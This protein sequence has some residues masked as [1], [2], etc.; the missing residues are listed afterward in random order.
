MNIYIQGASEHNLKGID[1]HIGD[2]L[3][4][5]TG[6]SGSGKTSL[7]FDTLYHEARRRLLSVLSNSRVSDGP[8]LLSP[9]KVTSITG[10]GPAVLVGQNVLNRNP[11]STLATASGLHPFLRLLFTNY[12]IR[13]CPQCAA[14]VNV[15]TEDEILERVL[16]LAGKGRLQVQVPLV[17]GIQG[18]HRTL[19]QLLTGEFDNEALIVDGHI[20]QSQSLDPLQAHDIEVLVG[21]LD[22]ETQTANIRDAVKRAASMGAPAIR[23]RGPGI[24]VTLSRTAVCPECGTLFNKLEAK[25]FHMVCLHCGG[26]GC[27]FCLN[28]G[29]HP[30]AAHVQWNGLN[31]PELLAKPVNE[32]R[33]LFIKTK[34][35]ASAQRL[36]R[37]I[38]RRLDTLHQVGLDYLTLDRPSP[39]LSRGESQRVRLAVV[40]SCRLE[41]MLHILDEPTIGQHPADIARFL[42]IF[43]ELA[44]PVVYVEHDRAAAMVADKAIELGPGAGKDG[45]RVTFSGTPSELW[46]AD[47]PTGRYFSLREHVMKPETR[48]HPDEFISLRG[49]YQH[50]LKNIDIDIPVGRLTVVTGV[51]GSGKST[52]VEDVLIPSM[53]AKKPVGCK[54]IAGPFRKI[55]YIDQSPIGH[56]PRSN[57][58]TYTKLSD[59]IRDLYAQATG[60]SSSHFSFNRPEG[61]CPACSGMGSIEVKMQLIYPLWIQCT[62]C[63]GKRFSEDILTSRVS[64]G[65]RR[66]SIAEFYQLSIEEAAA[67]FVEETRIPQSEVKT[68]RSILR[69]LN[70]VGLGYLPLGQPSTTLSGGEAQR[71]KLSKY[72]GRNHIADHLLVLDEPSTGLHPQDLNGLLIV[73][74]RLIQ[75]GATVV[76]IEHNT[77][78]IRAADWIIDLGP[79]GGPEG[80]QLLFSGAAPGLLQVTNSKTAWA[81]KN[82]PMNISKKEVKTSAHSYSDHIT[83]RNGRANNLKGVNVDIPKGKL[84]V[85]TGLSGSGKSSLVNNVLE[86]EAQRRYLESLSMYE[87]QGTREGPEAPVDAIS[88]LGVTLAVRDTQAHQWTALSQFTRRASVGKTSELSNCLSVL[89]AQAGERSC[90]ECGNPMERREEWVCQHCGSK[91]NIAQPRHFLTENYSSACTRCTGTGVLFSPKPEKLIVA[92]DKPLCRGAMYSPGYWPQTYLCQDQPVIPALGDRYGFDPDET[93]WN[94]IP[95]KAKKAFLFGDD[96]PITVTYRSKASGELKTWTRVWEG[97]YGGWV[98][99]WDVHGTYTDQTVC[100]EC[101]GSGLRREYM[102]VTLAD[103]NMHEL[104]E[105]PLKRLGNVLNDLALPSQAD[106]ATRANLD[107]A[108][109]RLSFINKVGLGYLHLDRASGTLSAGE[110]QRIKLAGLLG[111]RLASLTVLLDEPSR[112]M[113]PNELDALRKVLEDLRDSD[114]TVIVVEHDLQIIKAADHII[115]LGP[116]AGTMGGKIV[117]TGTP[118]DIADTDT[119]T[120]KWLRGEGKIDPGGGRTLGN[121]TEWLAITG[122]KEN[123][124]R[125]LDVKIPLHALVGVCGVSG[126]GKSTLII[127]TL[128]RALVHKTHTTSFAREPLEPG[129]YDSI[130]GMPERT[131]IVDQARENIHNPATFLGLTA[132]L[133]KLFAATPDAKALGLNEKR[134]GVPCSSCSGTGLK[135]MDMAFLPDV[136]VECETCTGTGCIPEAKEVHFKGISLPEVNGLTLEEAYNL[137]SEEQ[138]LARP[139]KVTLEVGLGYLVWQQ[140]AHTLSGGEAQR[141]KIVKELCRRT[142][143]STLYI[144]DEPTV[145]QHMEDVVKLVQVLHRLVKA[146]HSV[147]VIEHQPHV[148]ASCDWII[149]LGP[150][151]GPEGGNLIA[152]GHPTEVAHMNTPTARYIR[153]ALMVL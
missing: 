91:A 46:A 64:F 33:K 98:R 136:F 134:L 6:I 8:N 17:H 37:E 48:K 149:E 63:E 107:T 95:E 75:N 137:F 138:V 69:A 51:S 49:A 93:P 70:D 68:A 55:V 122:A 13:H 88:G 97:F 82:E 5:I 81:L 87:R 29:I 113:H 89:L 31:L 4:V 143:V 60:L 110:A 24:D 65:E 27:S 73:I 23:V 62:H 119:V 83:I 148:L 40:L 54:T 142:K 22:A 2:G 123:N 124:L 52:L 132:P 150:G 101:H 78:I 127:D 85:V 74:E 35:P 28:T 111:S 105:M 56:N 53:E 92:P 96:T 11:L 25:H 66:L 144:L 38:M 45:G 133:I 125:G 59:I 84:T 139:L 50:N 99:D 58:A 151:G 120:G 103:Y 71:V 102:V 147:I 100:P 14:E 41:D 67:L 130:V 115:E 116:G 106:S 3:T 44:G 118:R 16:I 61:A 135:R 21:V 20:Y 76:I 12:G 7:V 10:L 19:I 32:V 72:L 9:A 117:A 112:G 145:G 57:P 109:R 30:Q 104:N 36:R 42:P 146:R 129:K 126:S 43:R 131:V 77:D 34:M 152:F 15:L 86:A 1:V 140:P 121:E 26:K 114:N 108:R 47:T 153:E 94:E 128:G 18:S 79:G 39:T 80:G 90:L 141:L